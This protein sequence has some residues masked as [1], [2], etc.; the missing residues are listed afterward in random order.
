[1]EKKT[2]ASSETL[3]GNEK[4]NRIMDENNPGKYISW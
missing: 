3:Q 2:K 4:A 1:M